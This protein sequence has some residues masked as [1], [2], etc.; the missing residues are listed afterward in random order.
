MVLPAPLGDDAARTGY[1]LL[2]LGTICSY[3]VRQ[4]T[5]IKSPLVWS[6]SV[7]SLK[8]GYRLGYNLRASSIDATT[9]LNP[10]LVY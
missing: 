3:W 4:I 9:P 1:D 2:V 8:M 10:R 5:P 6:L 7:T